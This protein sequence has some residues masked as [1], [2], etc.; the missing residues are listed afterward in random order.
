MLASGDGAGHGLCR[1]RKVPVLQLRAARW[2]ADVLGGPRAGIEASDGQGRS[3]GTIRR[4]LARRRAPRPFLTPPVG[5]AKRKSPA[6]RRGSDLE[7]SAHKGSRHSRCHSMRAPS[8]AYPHLGVSPAP[9]KKRRWHRSP[10]CLLPWPHHCGPWMIGR[11]PMAVTYFVTQDRFRRQLVRSDH[12]IRDHDNEAA[13]LYPSGTGNEGFGWPLRTSA[14]A[15]VTASPTSERW[16][17]SE[18][19]GPRSWTLRG[20]ISRSAT[21]PR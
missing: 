5:D 21:R 11:P 18:R 15:Q 4:P 16:R 14:P 9:S 8:H 6:I 7:D 13:V 17:C 12:L 3:R 2:S 1:S 10:T 19:R 20:S